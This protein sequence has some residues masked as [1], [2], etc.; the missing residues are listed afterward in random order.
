MPDFTGVNVLSVNAHHSVVCAT[1]D[2]ATNP[3][4]CWGTQSDA[5]H[6]T[7]GE[8]RVPDGIN[9]EGAI[10]T[11]G[12]TASGRVCA[13]TACTGNGALEPGELEHA[14]ACAR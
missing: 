1:T 14:P 6:G 3:L 7:K 13:I 10:T 2:A 12:F 9:V 11:N 5:P 8:L 4:R